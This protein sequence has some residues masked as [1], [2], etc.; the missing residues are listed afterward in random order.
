MN[1]TRWWGWIAAA[2][3]LAGC[4]GGR[5][6]AE[7]SRGRLDAPAAARA[8]ASACDA[9]TGAATEA[10]GLVGHR[11]VGSEC[12]HSF[13]GLRQ[14]AATDGRRRAQ[15]AAAAANVIKPNAPP[16][17]ATELFDWAEQNY[18]HFFP[19]HESNRT[20]VPY[21]YRYYPTT[22]NHVAVANGLVYVQ[23]PL[24]GG[25]LLF[26]DELVDFTCT[27]F[28]DR[29]EPAPT[30]K[31]CTAPNS[32]LVGFNVCTPNADQTGSVPSGTTV[33]YLDSSGPTRGSASYTCNDGTLTQ[34]GG[35]ACDLAEPLAC[36][37]SG[38]SWTVGGR[39]C[40]ANAGEP[41]QLA[42]GASHVFKASSGTVG[43]ADYSC[44]N[45]SLSPV[46]TPSC[47][48]PPAVSCQPASVSWTV[49][50][51]TCDAD[52]VPAQIADGGSFLFGDITGATTG[53]ATF[54]CSA[55]NLVQLQGVCESIPH[56]L[57]SFGGDGGAAD[58]GANG[59]GTA[60][61]G[62]PIVGGLVQVVD[63]NG[64][65][66]SATTD[67]QGYF[68][69]KL[70]GFQPPLLVRVTRPDGVVRV[71]LSVQ[72]LKTNGYIFI[73]VTGLT[74]KIA[75]EIAKAADL[76]GAASLTPAI[77][78]A[79]PNALIAAINAIRNHPVVN[80]LL[81]ESGLDPS[82][83]DPLTIPFRPN[84]S[85]H[86]RVLDHIVVTTDSN[87]DTQIQSADCPAP[88]SWT[89]G[90]V[91]CTPDV[92]EETVVPHGRTVVHKDTVGPTTGT[93]GY[94]CLRAV[95]QPPILPSCK[96]G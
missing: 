50:A 46:G 67:A 56:I 73:S 71:S 86:D 41:T 76:G 57:D 82:T 4:G 3:L 48:P 55:G 81:I 45:G 75:A 89:V 32:W 87:G 51:N 10:A 63:R 74:T 93:V 65:R 83:F 16:L 40:V 77:I 78:E 33:A 47:N 2:L 91:T 22:Q 90:G 13:A 29:C 52:S 6:A 31:P 64:K 34:K 72:P 49:G 44:F 14:A 92:G 15:S 39:T 24:S 70:T 28:P 21:V 42:S 69:V 79:N 5:E 30:G 12:L 53:N 61:D 96:A 7:A 62:A 84:G 26:I 18:A 68:R 59:D 37:T 54:Q 35:L 95:L 17:T 88:T 85:G 38:L 43:S 8:P 23:G 25:T 27:V 9:S 36:N 66:T 80:P 60:G 11:R 94:T 1:T 20:L 58:G 19:G